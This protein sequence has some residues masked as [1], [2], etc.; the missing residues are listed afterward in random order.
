MVVSWTYYS[1]SEV[2]VSRSIEKVSPVKI[3]MAGK[4]ITIG[5]QTTGKNGND[6]NDSIWCYRPVSSSG[7]LALSFLFHCLFPVP[8][9]ENAVTWRQHIPQDS[10]D[11]YPFANN[12]LE[13]DKQ[14]ITNSISIPISTTHNTQTPLRREPVKK[15]KS[16]IERQTPKPNPCTSSILSS[17]LSTPTKNKTQNPL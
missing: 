10:A 16:R 4:G 1:G 7:G 5:M 12:T 9:L 13:Q 15:K 14:T 6:N 2:Q 8:C 11:H 3:R 17:P